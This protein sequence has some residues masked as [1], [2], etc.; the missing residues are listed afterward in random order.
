MDDEGV[1]GGAA[2][3]LED[4][5][6]GLCRERVGAQAVH[7]LGGEGDHLVGLQQGHRGRQGG[8]ERCGVVEVGEHVDELRG[9]GGSHG[10]R[11]VGEGEGGGG[12]SGGK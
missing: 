2:F 10:K 9:S 5:G 12:E 7:G 4:L 1:V 3:C 8:G 11:R 6:D